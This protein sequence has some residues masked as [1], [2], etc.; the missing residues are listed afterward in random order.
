MCIQDTQ[1]LPTAGF[2]TCKDTT[3]L[4]LVRHNFQP[5]KQVYPVVNRTQNQ[6]IKLL[7]AQSH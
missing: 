4:D 5:N 6:S 2:T 3:F 1:T 7:Q